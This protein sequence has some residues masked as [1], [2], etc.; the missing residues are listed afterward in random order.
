MLSGIESAAFPGQSD[1]EVDRLLHM[2]VVGGGPTGVEF[3]L[4]PDL[5]LRGLSADPSPGLNFMIS[6]LTT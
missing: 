1:Q 6:L 3:A 5:K 2:V 4:V